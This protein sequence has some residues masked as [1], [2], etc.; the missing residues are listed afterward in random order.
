MQYEYAAVGPHMPERNLSRMRAQRRAKQ[1]GSLHA[2]VDNHLARIKRQ[3][4]HMTDVDRRVLDRATDEL[5]A[6]VRKDNINARFTS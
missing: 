2:A 6:N 1:P 4:G 3:G 5:I